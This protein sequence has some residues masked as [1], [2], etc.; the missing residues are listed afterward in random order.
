M[1]IEGKAGILFMGDWA[2]GEFSQRQQGARKG[3]HLRGA[4]GTDGMFTFIADTFVFFKQ[5]NQPAS[6]GQLALA[7]L[8]VTPGLSGAGCALS[9]ARFRR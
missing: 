2:K 9:K 1:V 3:L 4:P 5:R 7:S 6:T 8:I